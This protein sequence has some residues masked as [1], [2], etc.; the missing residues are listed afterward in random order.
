[1]R[2]LSS[3]QFHV[4]PLTSVCLIVEKA[5]LASRARVATTSK[6]RKVVERLHNE[7]ERETK[8]KKKKSTRG[9][10][11]AVHRFNSSTGS[12]NAC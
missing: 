2:V 5:T 10:A 11:Y 12:Q 3:S 9:G 8:E 4:L 6:R 1:M 7:M